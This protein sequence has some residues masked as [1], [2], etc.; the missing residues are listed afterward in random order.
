MEQKILVTGYVNPDLDATACAFGYA[1]YLQKTGRPAV[2]GVFGVPH[3]EA[4]FV[5][6][7]FHIPRPEDA[8]RLKGDDVPVVLVDA[9]D[10]NGLPDELKPAQ[11][12]E[13]IDHRQVHQA[14]QFPHAKV[15]L[16]LVGSAATLIAEK[17]FT[18]QVEISVQAAALLY[19]AIIS[20]TVNF[21]ANV[22]T[23]RDR[24]MAGWLA[25]KV[26]LPSDYIHQMFAAKSQLTKSVKEE[27]VDDLATF[28]FNGHSVGVAQLEIIEAG[29]FVTSRRAEVLKALPEIKAELQLEYLFLTAI[30]LEQATNTFVVADTAAQALLEKALGVTFS[31]GIANRAGIMMRKT[32]VP[33]VKSELEAAPAE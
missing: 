31:N 22:V 19:S 11:V 28:V 26:D 6:S 1:E 13:I 9:S 12:I 33:L 25:T 15:Q 3:K 30:D 14:E 7:F 20:N 10:L 18:N 23:D 32:I 17:F 5:L 2:A 8:G 29:T 24:K 16:E 4:E 21:Q 27:L